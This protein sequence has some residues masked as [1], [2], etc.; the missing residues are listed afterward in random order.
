[1]PQV[2]IGVL[3]SGSGTNLQSL[4]D[5]IETGNIKGKITVVISNRKDA[6]GLNRARQKNIDALYIRQ[7]DYESFENFNDAII[8][9]L[10]KHN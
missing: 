8:D 7:K 10:K 3:I 2:K 4:I 6:Y 5:N 1:M 9:E